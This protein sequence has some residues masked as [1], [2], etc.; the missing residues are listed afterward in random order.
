MPCEKADLPIACTVRAWYLYVCERARL[1]VTV[2][3]ITIAAMQC[4]VDY[5]RHWDTSSS[6]CVVCGRFVKLD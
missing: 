5:L 2:V 6:K 1:S 4:G 3:M